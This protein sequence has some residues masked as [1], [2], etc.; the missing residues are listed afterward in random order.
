[1]GNVRATAWPPLNLPYL[2]AV[3]P[4]HYQIEVI[5]ENIQPFRYT[6]ADIVGITAYT[7]SAY[8]AYQI[9]GQYRKQNIPTVMGGIHAS[10]MPEEASRYFDTVVIGEAE[11]I[12][13]RVLE[14]FEGGRLQKTYRGSWP[15]LDTLPIPRR[16]ILQNRY[17]SWGSLQT[18]RGCP[19]NCTFCSVTA[20]NGHRFRRR[21]LESVIEEL[22]QIPQRRVLLTDDN[23][24]GFGPK[25][26]EWAFAFFTRIL[27]KG[28]KKTFFAQASILFGE[29]EELIR[30]ASRAGLRIVFVGMES[31][32]PNTLQSYRKGINLDRLNRNRYKELINRIRKNGISFLGAF[33]LGD[34]HDERSVFHATLEFVRSSHI[35]VLQV[36]KLTPLP[37]TELWKTME[38]EGRIL[39][40]NFPKAWE[41]YRF[42]KMVFE[43]ARMSAEE[44][45]E[46][47]TYLRS[48]YYSVWETVKRTISTLLTTKSLAA[49]ILAYGFNA[50]YRKAFRNSEHYQLY[51]RTN[52]KRKFRP[53]PH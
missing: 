19:M 41:G 10:M 30:L 43:P 37:G 24:I 38:R 33:V 46:G 49:T 3:T 29:D 12:W 26:S 11:T 14:D 47:F 22:E 1:L 50:S 8:R 25:D 17:Y 34:D 31:V 18:S 28:I 48:T 40:R 21:P 6:D 16:D 27:E 39:D 35:D 9:A 2:A 4:Q 44:V 5:D 53:R 7:S 42:T 32:N 45:Y 36:S 51:G 23:I 52:L 20:F 15:S 13:P